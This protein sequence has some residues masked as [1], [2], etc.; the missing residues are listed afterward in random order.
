MVVQLLRKLGHLGKEVTHVDPSSAAA[1][2]AIKTLSDVNK[3]FDV[4]NLC[5]N[6]K[7]GQNVVEDMGTLGVKNVFVQPG[8]EC[9]L[10]QKRAEELGIGW[11]QGCV[12]VES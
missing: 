9:S 1:Q 11:H 10:L 3:P 5:A 8:A 2:D 12:L 6:P 7:V 4:V